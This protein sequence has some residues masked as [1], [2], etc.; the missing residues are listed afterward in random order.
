MGVPT[1]L[2]LSVTG[3]PSLT[4]SEENLSTNLGATTN[5]FSI[6]FSVHYRHVKPVYVSNAGYYTTYLSLRYGYLFCNLSS[7]TIIDFNTAYALGINFSL[8]RCDY[9]VLEIELIDL[10]VLFQIQ[11]P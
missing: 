1:A 5:S 11:K 8:A 2:T 7:I 3:S 4:V 9:K 6:T 10:Y